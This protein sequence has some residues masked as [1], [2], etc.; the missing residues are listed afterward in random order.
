M[1]FRHYSV[2]VGLVLILGL[3]AP[4]SAQRRTSGS[5][6]R[7]ANH[8][9]AARSGELLT[10][11][12][13][14]AKVAPEE[15]AKANGLPLTA[16]CAKGNDLLFQRMRPIPILTPRQSGEI[17][18]KRIVFA[19]GSALD[20]DDVWKQGDTTWYRLNG[21]SQSVVQDHPINR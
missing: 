1:T 17:I 5:K 21:T 14:R 16:A 19:D 10:N 18:G 13:T 12:A 20:V 11:L 6:A 15:L 8:T 3:S 2:L 9:I 7:N 4:L